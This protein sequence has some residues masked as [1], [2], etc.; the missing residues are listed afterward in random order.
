MF[1]EHVEWL[2]SNALH[3]TQHTMATC[4]IVWAA[5]AGLLHSHAQCQFYPT[6]IY[7]IFIL[8]LFQKVP[9]AA[10][11][12]PILCPVGAQI[13]CHICNTLFRY[14]KWWKMS[15]FHP[16]LWVTKGNRETVFSLR[17]T[18]G[19]GISDLCWLTL[20]TPWFNANPNIF[21]CWMVVF[22]QTL[23]YYLFEFLV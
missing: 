9:P 21:G 14:I 10:W 2:H 15:H 11:G 8:M 16:L 13:W 5:S 4:V 12:R 22:H 20:T 1:P 18:P 23:F 6:I 17:G 3:G 7:Y 19:T